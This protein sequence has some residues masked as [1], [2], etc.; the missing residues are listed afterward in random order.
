M[1]VAFVH[2]LKQ[3]WNDIWLP[4][5]SN[6]IIG[7][8]LKQLKGKQLKLNTLW[9]QHWKTQR[10]ILSA[11]TLFLG[12]LIIVLLE[13]LANFPKEIMQSTTP[14]LVLLFFFLTLITVFHEFHARFH[15]MKCEKSANAYQKITLFPILKKVSKTYL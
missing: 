15:V 14:E 8:W 12:M 7:Y 9:F 1:L 10:V 5:Y 11:A 2:F 13:N 3:S 6:L 4:H